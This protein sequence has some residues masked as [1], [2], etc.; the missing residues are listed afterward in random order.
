MK[1]R[2]RSSQSQQSAK[3]IERQ[4]DKESDQDMGKGEVKSKLKER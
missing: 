2:G 4:G 1:K 3:V